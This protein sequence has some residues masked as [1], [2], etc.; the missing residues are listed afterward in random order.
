MRALCLL[1]LFI[2]LACEINQMDAPAPKPDDPYRL[3][4]WRD[5]ETGLDH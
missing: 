2:W 4:R 1:I 5:G 3:D